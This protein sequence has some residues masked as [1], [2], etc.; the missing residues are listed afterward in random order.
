MLFLD[1]EERRGME[2]TTLARAGMVMGWAIP[3]SGSRL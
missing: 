1:S 2:S 3:E